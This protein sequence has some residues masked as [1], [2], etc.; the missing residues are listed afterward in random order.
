MLVPG[1]KGKFDYLQVDE[2]F[3]RLL[4]N[5]TGNG[6]LDVFDLPDG[7]LRQTVAIGAA[8]D[9]SIDT[10][11][12]KY[13]VTV[14]DRRNLTI[15][16]RQTLK[17]EG[18]VPLPGVPDGCA[19]DSKNRFV[20]VD[21]RDGENVWVVDPSAR[22]IVATI[23]V[24]TA[25]EYILYD[26]ASD[27]IYQNIKSKPVTLAIDPAANSVIETW[28][29]EPAESPHGLAINPETHRLFSAAE[30][31]NYRYWTLSLEMY[32]PPQR[33]RPALTR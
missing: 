11:R 19:Y 9:V 8:Q 31:G 13:Y 2:Q 7:K 25:P 22:R 6:T 15:V 24:P 3:R 23:R 30:T 29:T 27:R 32:L 20:Y 26:P 28:S 14:S 21:Q 16:D 5:H 33:S 18:E 1:T 10:E 17:V 4:A 12:S